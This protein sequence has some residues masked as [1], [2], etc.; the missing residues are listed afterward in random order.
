[1]FEV[2][3]KTPLDKIKDT[4]LYKTIKSF[5][6]SMI[7]EAKVVVAVLKNRKSYLNL[8]VKTG[9]IEE[10]LEA[11]EFVYQ[12]RKVWTLNDKNNLS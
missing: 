9:S 6:G 5:V 2:N 11:I 3:K 10:I 8:I 12:S 7:N 4:P 1:M